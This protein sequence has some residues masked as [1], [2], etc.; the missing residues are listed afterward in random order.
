ML[1]LCVRPLCRR[2]FR[3]RYALGPP[4][5]P[6]STKRRHGRRTPKENVSAPRAHFRDALEILVKENPVAPVRIRL[7]LGSGAEDG[8]AA[9]LIQQEDA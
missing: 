7:K 5:W 9:I 3:G 8:A 2:P 6:A 4:A 1:P